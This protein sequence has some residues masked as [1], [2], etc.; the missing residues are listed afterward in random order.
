MTL[1]NLKAHVEGLDVGQILQ[2]V[3]VAL[4][5]RI[6]WI[7][8][9]VQ[10]PNEEDEN[11][12]DLILVL[13]RSLGSIYAQHVRNAASDQELHIAGRMLQEV[14]LGQMEGKRY[15]LFVEAVVLS[16]GLEYVGQC[17]KNAGE[18]RVRRLRRRRR[19]SR[20]NRNGLTALP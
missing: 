6:L 12:L 10:L 8:Q 5:R 3:E 9:T 15:E 14:V 19:R 13:V 1:L 16:H 17:L 7:L 20:K 18:T 4:E 11:G 2:Q